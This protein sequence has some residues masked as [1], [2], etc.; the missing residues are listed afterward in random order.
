MT[1]AVYVPGGGDGGAELGIRLIGRVGAPDGGGGEAGR[2]AWVEE[3]RALVRLSVVVVRC[4][5]D[6][7]GVAVAVHVPGDGDSGAELRTLLVARSRP[8]RHIRG[9]PGGCAMV[10]ESRPLVRLLTVV[11]GRTDDDVGVAVAVHV[12]GSGDGGAELCIC[13]VSSDHPVRRVRGRETHRTAAIDVDP[14]G[15]CQSD[16]GGDVHSGRADDD[17]GETVAVHVP[18]NG[19]GGAEVGVGLLAR[20]R[21]VR[22]AGGKPVRPAVVDEDRAHVQPTSV[23]VGRTD[24]DVRV[25]V[26]VDVTGGGDGGAEVSVFLFPRGHPVRRAGRESGRVAVIREGRAFVRPD[27]VVVGSADDDVGVAVPV[28]VTGQGDG[29]PEVGLALVAL[30]A[31]GRGGAKSRLRAVVDEDRPLAGLTG[32]VVRRT[33]DE[34]G[35]AVAVDVTGGGEGVAEVS[36]VLVALTDPIRGGR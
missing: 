36:V 1:V 13:L 6:D 2:P 20:G 16:G 17:V 4:A 8:V 5:D 21:P 19:D 32:V 22:R 29:V 11:A 7:V 27:A 33:D 9:K 10:D 30:G 35:V 18:G 3:G 24:D 25:A 28:H 15:I 34:V 31:P 12:P 26:A 14:P 23:V